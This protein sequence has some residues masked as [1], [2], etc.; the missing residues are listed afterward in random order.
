M[1]YPDK[2]RILL[3]EDVYEGACDG[4]GRDRYTVAHEISHLLLHEGLGVRLMREDVP[5][6][7]FEDSE[8]QANALAGEIL[9]PYESIVNLDANAIASRYQVSLAAAKTQLRATHR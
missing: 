2:H 1:T 6:K 9:M 3:R 5:H 4:R 7:A 8:W